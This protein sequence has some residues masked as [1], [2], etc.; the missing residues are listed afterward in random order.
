MNKCL[1]TILL[2]LNCASALAFSYTLELSESEIQERVDA[3]M[4]LEKKKFFVTTVLTNPVIDLIKSTNELGLSTDVAFKAPGNIVGS[5]RVSFTGMLRYD[6]DTGAFYFDDLKLVSLNV[7]KVSPE[8]LSKIKK[9]LQSV[10]SQFLAKKPVFRFKD[11]NLKHN[12]A[13][14]TLK[15]ITVDNEN[16][17]IELGLF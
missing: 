8:S 6:N 2:V 11:N 4:P 9:V 7:K 1:L 5:G 17:I 3:M 15:S 12:L 13:K 10:A 14:S 16:L